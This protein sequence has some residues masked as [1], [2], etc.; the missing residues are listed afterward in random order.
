MAE[1]RPSGQ[2]EVG[3][4]RTGQGL[5]EQSHHLEGWWGAVKAKGM[6]WTPRGLTDSTLASL[7]YSGNNYKTNLIK[8]EHE[9]AVCRKI[10]Q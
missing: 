10:K 4:S 8:R 5:E 6:V 9:Q 7:T 3:G 2:A 1:G